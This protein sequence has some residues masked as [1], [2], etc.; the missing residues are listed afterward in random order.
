MS[1]DHSDNTVINSYKLRKTKCLPKTKQ[2][3][4][5]RKK[6]EKERKKEKEVRLQEVKQEKATVNLLPTS[7][8]LTCTGGF[9]SSSAFKKEPWA[10]LN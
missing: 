4:Q 5:K 7:S 10:S 6:K 3:Q 2:Q 9:H 8:F 1:P